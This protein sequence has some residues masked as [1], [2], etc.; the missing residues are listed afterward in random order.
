M[1][2]VCYLSCGIGFYALSRPALRD[3]VSA[4]ACVSLDDVQHVV[5]GLCRQPQK[6][7]PALEVSTSWGSTCCARVVRTRS[8]NSVSAWRAAQ[9]LFVVALWA[10][11]LATELWKARQE[12]CTAG[13]FIAYGTQVRCSS[14][15]PAQPAPGECVWRRPCGACAG[16][17][18]TES[19][20]TCPMTHAAG[21]L[22]V[23]LWVG[24]AVCQ[25]TAL[26]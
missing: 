14:F 13:Y 24:A 5:H 15:E 25:P 18:S 22:L 16:E 26:A 1:R 9:L 23:S 8:A 20:S 7:G 17:R 4:C 11:Y 3:H 12:R 19:S 2:P 6:H 10:I 21:P